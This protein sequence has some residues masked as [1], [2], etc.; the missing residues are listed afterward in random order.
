MYEPLP[1]PPDDSIVGTPDRR[2][3]SVRRTAHINMTWPDGQGTAMELRGRSRD[4][5]TPADGATRVLDEARMVVR[6]GQARTVESIEVTPH[7]DGIEGLVGAQGGSR[8]RTAIDDAIPGERE[9]ATPLHFLL[10]DIA[11]SSL[12]GG[13]SWS[14]AQQPLYGPLPPLKE[15]MPTR[16]P[17][18]ANR[19]ICSGLRPN[20]YSD[21]RKEFGDFGGHYLRLPGDL[22]SPDPLAWH[23]LDPPAVPCMRRRRRV[24]I[25][26]EGD[27]IEVDA[28]FRDSMWRW[29]G[30]E[31]ALHEYT[32]QVTVDAGSGT[33][34]AIAA[35]PRVLPFPECPWAAPHVGTLVGMQVLGFRTSVQDTLTELRAC[36]HLND[37]L[38]CL[39]EVS[40]LATN[41]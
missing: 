6:V 4:L 41:L 35:Q 3:G 25:W 19:I 5:L 7:R 38:R 40:A 20:G 11:G 33:V 26:Q 39:A 8:F 28:H 30:V 37:M 23:E 2:P 16:D 10:D 17:K 27:A 9:A 29:D 36:T 34:R 1:E 14:Q 24:D 18:R 31:L 13:F 15:P 22:S 21:T 12:I 32:L